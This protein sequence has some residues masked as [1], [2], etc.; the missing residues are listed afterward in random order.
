MWYLR[1]E[2]EHNIK[3]YSR[4]VDRHGTRVETLAHAGKTRPV[5]RMSDTTAMM[6][7]I[8]LYSRDRA[9]ESSGQANRPT[10]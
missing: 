4:N 3:I 5:P 2:I 8:V 6:M 7:M 9:L 10:I 1:L